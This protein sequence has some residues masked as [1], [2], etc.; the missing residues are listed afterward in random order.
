MSN[1]AAARPSWQ[2]QF[3]VPTRELP[4]AVV[5]LVLFVYF[6]LKSPYF[7][8]V[9]NGQNLGR[10]FFTELAFLAMAEGLVLI[11][12]GIDLSVAAILALS[13]VTVGLIT[14]KY[15]GNVWFASGVALLVGIVAGSI[16][17]CLIVFVRLS[18]IVATLTTLTLYRGIALGITGGQ[19]FSGFP[20]SFSN[21]GNS[22]VF[23]IPMQVLVLAVVLAFVV[24]VMHRTIVGRWVY[25]MGGNPAAAR[26]AGLPV[27]RVTIGVYA[28]AG[29]LS[30][31]AGVIAAARFNTSR[32]DFSTGVELDAITAAILGGISIAGGR[33]FVFSAVLG[34][35]ALA[36]LRDGMTLI[37]QSGFLQTV[38]IGVLLIL[39]VL[40]DRALQRMRRRREMAQQLATPP[41]TRERPTV[42][43]AT[44]R[45]SP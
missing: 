40:L 8:T 14:V 2:S 41:T 20:T 17:G 32:A 22:V 1:S 43:T 5:L 3:R 4:V 33:G 26:F 36:V 45:P 23:G 16:N 18:P 42:A 21:L 44:E 11:M 13:A 27:A 6:W 35:L 12:R 28:A 29:F 34:A 30:A 19:D 9:A 7:V 24:W 38:V 31:L 10:A 37:G 15:G 25:A 39:A